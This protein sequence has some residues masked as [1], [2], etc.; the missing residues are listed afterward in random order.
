MISTSAA[1]AK[2][3]KKKS[4]IVKR[5]TSFGKRGLPIR[6]PRMTRALVNRGAIISLGVQCRER[7]TPA[8]TKEEDPMRRETRAVRCLLSALLLVTIVMGISAQENS[9]KKFL[10]KPLVIEDQGSFFIGG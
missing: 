6:I 8:S 5:K 7:T 9:Q 10:K 4:G 2:P 1:V 3:A